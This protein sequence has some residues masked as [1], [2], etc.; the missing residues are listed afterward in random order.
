[1]DLACLINSNYGFVGLILLH[2]KE[3][4]KPQ[5][6]HSFN[7]LLNFVQSA[8]GMK[9]LFCIFAHPDDEAFG[10]GGSIA[11]FSKDRK[12]YLICVT[13]G[14][15]KECFQHE[16]HDNLG[17]IRKEEL[18][19][20]AKILGIQ[21]VFFLGFPDGGLCNNLYHE[22]A[23]QTEVLLETYDPDTLLTFENNGISGHIDHIAVSF[24]T[25]FLYHKLTFIKKLMYYAES[26]EIIKELR[27]DYFIHMP[28]G[29]RKGKEDLSID[30]SS[31]WETKVKA[32]CV[33]KS[34]QKDVD[35]N[36]ALL[37]KHP[38]IEY[39]LVESKN[40]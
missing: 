15:A 34:Q 1:L 27:D 38:K 13:D 12:V 31:V 11:T 8:K 28:E 36:L 9:P 24:I 32:M 2:K 5:N 10:P 21:D 20:S 19:K 40:G 14:N 23:G 16:K 25:A 30:T 3:E 4:L 33:H 6:G 7:L 22:I 29:I 26:E 35:T 37:T 39:F 17:D 18:L